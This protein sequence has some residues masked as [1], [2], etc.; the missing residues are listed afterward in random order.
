MGE[1]GTRNPCP[2]GINRLTPRYNV[3]TAAGRIIF[4]PSRLSAVSRAGEGRG[5]SSKIIISF[6]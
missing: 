5:L 4:G 6:L 1:Y 3:L 2:H